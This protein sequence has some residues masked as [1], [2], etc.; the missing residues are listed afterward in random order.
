MPEPAIIDTTVIQVKSTTKDTYGNLIV[1][2]EVGEDFKIAAKREFLF[3]VF[4]EGRAVKLGWAEYMHRKYI[5]RAEL[6]D[7]KPPTEKQVEPITAGV[8]IKQIQQTI[9]ATIAD[10]KNRSFA[11]AY[12]KDLAVAG[13]IEINKIGE[14]ARIFEKYLNGES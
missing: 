1:T 6:F 10:N 13:K 8:E 12:A 9:K 2:P 7:G 5:A 14:Y 3:E 4:Q 11:L